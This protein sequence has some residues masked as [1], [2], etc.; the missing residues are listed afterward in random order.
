MKLETDGGWDVY[1]LSVEDLPTMPYERFRPSDDEIAAGVYFTTFK[2]WEQVAGWFR[3]EFAA[4][5]VPDPYFTQIAQGVITGGTHS[6]GELGRLYQHVCE[7]LKFL[8]VLDRWDQGF[9]LDKPA[10]ILRTGYADSFQHAVVFI[11]MLR[12]AGIT[13]HPV[14]VNIGGTID[15]EAVCPQQFNHCLVAIERDGGLLYLDTSSRGSDFGVLPGAVQ[16]REAIII[17]PDK[18][19]WTVLELD[20]AERNRETITADFVLTRK[21][22]LSGTMSLVGTGNIAKGWRDYLWAAGKAGRKQALQNRLPLA[23]SGGRLAGIHMGE[24]KSLFEPV[25][26]SI[27]VEATRYADRFGPD[28]LLFGIPPCYTALVPNAL[29]EMAWAE[30]RQ[31]P[32]DF[33]MVMPAFLVEKTIKIKLPEGYIVGIPKERPDITNSIGRLKVEY[34]LDQ[35]RNELTYK[36]ILMVEALR[37][38]PSRYPEFRELLMGYVWELPRKLICVP[39]A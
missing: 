13:A 31:F 20:P 23:V 37:I 9:P 11:A 2:D 33:G 32:Y 4:V 10:D 39:G 1:N 26:F 12:E 27:D 18:H 22:D 38:E 28:T 25:E 8:P 6:H 14:L 36:I 30:E 5:L 7:K 34:L 21:G 35:E 24:H 29:G 17:Y 3:Q 19:E 15:Q 16:G